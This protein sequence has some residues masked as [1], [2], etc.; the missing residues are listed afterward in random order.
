M[1]ITIVGHKGQLGEALQGALAGHALQGLDLPEVDITRYPACAEPILG[2]APD[3]VLHIAAMTN[4]DGC[5]TDPDQAF[6]VNALGTRNVALACQALDVP[7]LYVSTDYVFRGD[8]GSPRYEYDLPNPQSAYAR[9]KLAGEQIVRDLLRKHYITRTAWLYDGTHRNFVTTMRRLATERPSLKVVTNEVGSPTYAK[10]LA[11][12]IA[13]LIRRPAYGIYHFA[14]TGVC[15]RFEFTKAILELSGL[16]D[17]PV[18][19]VDH[20]PRPAKVPARVELKNVMGAAL[21][22]A[23]R[24][25]REALEEC[26]SSVH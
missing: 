18:E 3:V 26:L 1:K 22:I 8:E 9:S 14:N 20:Y 2:F 4:V 5:E 21:G 25:W 19:P 24:P 17:Y 7:M 15:S 12:A 13:K 10:D 6:R 16:A 23:F 11:E